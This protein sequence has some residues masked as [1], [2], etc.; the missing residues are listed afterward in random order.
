MHTRQLI[1]LALWTEPIPMIM[2]SNLGYGTIHKCA[3][4]QREIGIINGCH[5]DG[6]AE[7]CTKL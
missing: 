7:T 4:C 6:F 5:Q 2:G 3:K 1:Q